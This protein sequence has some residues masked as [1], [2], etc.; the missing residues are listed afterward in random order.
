[1]KCAAANL[2]YSFATT[3]LKSRPGIGD[4]LYGPGVTLSTAAGTPAVCDDS[5]RRRS[6]RSAA[7][8]PEIT[9]LSIVAGRPVWTQSPARNTFRS[10]VCADGRAA[11]AA[12]VRDS[13]A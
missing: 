12:G 6:A 11:S 9:A 4:G 7:R 5:Y 1:M 13:V 10:G 3:T 2:R 8:L